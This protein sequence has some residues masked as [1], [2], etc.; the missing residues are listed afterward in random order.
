M[1]FSYVALV[2][3]TFAALAQGQDTE[4]EHE[5]AMA[6]AQKN[7][8]EQQH[9]LEQAQEALEQAAREV[10]RLSF[11]V[12]GPQINRIVRQFRTT[13][14]R[15]MLG[16]TVDDDKEGARITGVSPGGPAEEAGLRSGDV[17]TE[18]NDMSLAE[19]NAP[20]R[21]LVEEMSNVTAGDEVNLKVKRHGKDL[22]F[23][24]ATKQFEPQAYAFAFD[25][26]GS[27]DFDFDDGDVHV[28]APPF[29]PRAL[30]DMRP[31]ARMELVELTP[32]LG[33]YFGAEEGILVVR[34]PE[35]EGLDLIDGDVILEIGDR[36]PRSTTHAMRILRSFESGEEMQLEI[37]RDKRRRTIKFK[38]PEDKR[39][40]QR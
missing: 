14:R 19:S 35:K 9:E 5:R 24:V 33:S 7:L 20:T 10:A 28:F 34:A 30:H 27:F 22:E 2:L 8:E 31:W 13:G 32:A 15:A 18:V 3:L 4:D 23:V 29:S 12:A 11:N 39:V 38:V 36:K 25:E 17:V 21:A 37:L 16:V 26:D 1:K 6:E 40:S